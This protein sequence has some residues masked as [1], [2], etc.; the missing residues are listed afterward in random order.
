MLQQQPAEEP[1][2]AWS[3]PKNSTSRHVSNRTTRALEFALPGRRA[4]GT[5]CAV[6]ASVRIV[7]LLASAA[8][9]SGCSRFKVE[10]SYRDADNPAISYLFGQ[11]GKWSAEKTVQVPAGL[12]PHGSG[13]RWQGTFERRGDFIELTCT[14]VLRQEPLTGEFR[15]EP[16]DVASYNHR[17]RIVEAALVPEATEHGVD[18]VFAS[19]VNPL[20]A[21]KLVPAGG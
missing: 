10:G 15:D 3:L 11:D 12:F 17:L 13:R 19:D 18:P 20:G 2:T 21:R 7:L 5:C 4:V 1:P 9:L 6:K 14:A 8:V 16:T